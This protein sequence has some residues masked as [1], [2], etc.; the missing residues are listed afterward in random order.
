MAWAM[1][2]SKS[3]LFLISGIKLYAMRMMS[4]FLKMLSLNAP[5][6]CVQKKGAKRRVNNN[7]DS[8]FENG[9]ACDKSSSFN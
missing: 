2:V 9:L 8:F 4:A 6:N 1:L 3:A 7:D 5:K